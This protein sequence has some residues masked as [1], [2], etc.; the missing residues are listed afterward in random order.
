MKAI[1]YNC[2]FAP[3]VV[4]HRRTKACSFLRGAASSLDVA[5][6]RWASS[7]P[8]RSPAEG[9]RCP[10]MR[11]LATKLEFPDTLFVQEMAA[12][13]PIVGKLCD[14]GPVAAR[15]KAASNTLAEWRGGAP[16]RNRTIAGRVK[17]DCD[18]ELTRIVFQ[19]PMAETE[20]GG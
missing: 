14:C 4:A 13:M 20:K 6:A 16:A 5:R 2:A 11:F 7:L 1:M 10:L 12:G 8:N 18:A 15:P 17:M 19:K 9:I 3:S